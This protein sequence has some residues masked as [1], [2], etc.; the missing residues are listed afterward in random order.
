MDGDSSVHIIRP[1]GV[2]RSPP[3][4]E[5]VGRAPKP[6]TVPRTCKYCDFPVNSYNRTE[7]CHSCFKALVMETSRESTLD[8]KRD[9]RS[10]FARICR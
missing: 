6:S 10:L 5:I 8:E 9:A 4:Q 1:K 7:V 2:I 3:W